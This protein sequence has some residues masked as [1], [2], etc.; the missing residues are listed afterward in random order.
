MQKRLIP[1]FHVLPVK[2][3]LLKRKCCENV[4][5]R[6]KEERERR[7]F[8]LKIISCRHRRPCCD[9]TPY[10]LHVELAELFDSFDYRLDGQTEV[11]WAIHVEAFVA[12][13]L[14]MGGQTPQKFLLPFHSFS[15]SDR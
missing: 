8:V 12:F 10:P 9:A 7:K 13:G 2:K 11:I 15:S 4:E 6:G 14:W 1:K 3:L 5:G